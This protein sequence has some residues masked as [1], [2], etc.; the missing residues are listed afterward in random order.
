MNVIADLNAD[1]FSHSLLGGLTTAEFSL[2]A[3]L[4]ILRD[5]LPKNEKAPYNL[6]M[7]K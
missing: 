4:S 6:L 1:I 3:E 5:S 2:L 7:L